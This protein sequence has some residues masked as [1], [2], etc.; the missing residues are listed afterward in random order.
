[1][2]GIQCGQHSDTKP[3]PCAFSRIVIIHEGSYIDNESNI[4]VCKIRIQLS[5]G[6][7]MGFERKHCLHLQSQSVLYRNTKTVLFALQLLV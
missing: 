1:M 7:L 6:N 4:L 2:K 5:T 3:S